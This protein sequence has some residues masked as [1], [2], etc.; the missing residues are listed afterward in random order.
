[1]PSQ[2]DIAL[3]SA[4]RHRLLP[5]L[6]SGKQG[7]PVRVWVPRCSSGERAYWMAMVLTEYVELH[8]LGN[9]IQIFATDVDP[10][11]L[12]LA[13]DGTYSAS[14]AESMPEGYVARYFQSTDAGL[15]VSRRVRDCVLFSLHDVFSDPPFSKL[16]LIVATSLFHGLAEDVA[17]EL[18]QVLHFASFPKG[19]LLIEP[20]LMPRCLVAL[21]SAANEASGLLRARTDRLP[22]LPASRRQPYR[23]RFSHDNGLPPNDSDELAAIAQA[24]ERMLLSSYTPACIV[25]DEHGNVLYSL[26]KAGRYLHPPAGLPSTKIAEMIRPELSRLAARVLEGPASDGA[27]RVLTEEVELDGVPTQVSA[28]L[29][30]LVEFNGSRRLRALVFNEVLLQRPILVNSRQDEVVTRLRADLISSQNELQSIREEFRCS[31]EELQVSNEELVSL[32]EELQV[33]N[34]ELEAARDELQSVN[35]EVETVNGELKANIAELQRANDHS[36]NLFEITRLAVLFLDARLRIVNFT[37]AIQDLFSL[38]QSDRGRPLTDIAQ[39]FQYD[40]LSGDALEVMR[41]R[42]PKEAQVRSLSKRWYVLRILP[43]VSEQ[44]EL[45]G[46][47]LTFNDVTAVKLAEL[48]VTRSSAALAAELQRLRALVESAPV[49]IVLHDGESGTVRLNQRATELLGLKHGAR[50]EA[51]PPLPFCWPAE[52]VPTAAHA[53]LRRVTM[54]GETV[55]GVEIAVPGDNGEPHRL[56]INAAP[57]GSGSEGPYSTVTCLLDVTDERRARRAV[58]ER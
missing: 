46:V 13:R 8:G 31:G 29:R 49:G 41:A 34:E 19:R 44:G 36:R 28:I 11:A 35:E 48:E 32:N 53:D 26:G 45:D 17:G 1:M 40:D 51:E 58:R 52:A 57:L 24:A 2:E 22:V 3:L 4:L 14:I 27:P 54:A 7:R 38:I 30:N 21:F 55:D 56:L 42:S 15:Q 50:L 18:T 5:E 43:Y 20:E 47:L 37:P 12:S 23:R 16:D 33:A 9:D 10:A 25:L 6:F 39:R